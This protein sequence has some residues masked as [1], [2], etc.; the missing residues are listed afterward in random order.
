MA[1]VRLA[2][3][4]VACELL[5]VTALELLGYHDSGMPDWRHRHRDDVFCNVPVE[6]WRVVW[7]G[8]FERYQPDVVVTYANNGG[9]NHP[10]HLHAHYITVAAVER[11]GIPAKLYYIARGAGDFHRLRE[12]MVARGLDPPARRGRDSERPDPE[13]MARHRSTD[14]SAGTPDHHLGGRRS[15]HRAQA[16][17]PPR[18]CQPAGRI[19]VFPPPP[20]VVRRHLPLRDLHPL[21][22]HQRRPHS[23]G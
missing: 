4:Q 7:S 18:P 15:G 14:G 21:A 6:A 5:D 3:L 8:L 22:R 11:T 2:E 16:R 20:R 10:D 9:Y 13:R 1:R 17:R 12:T 23:G 19:V